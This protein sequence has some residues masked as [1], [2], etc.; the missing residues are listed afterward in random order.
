MQKILLS[1]LIFICSCILIF[2]VIALV[3]G[4]VTCV[5]EKIPFFI[6]SDSNFKKRNFFLKAFI[7][8]PLQFGK[9]LARF[10]PN[11]F[12][13]HGIIVFEGEQGAGKTIS[14]VQYAYTLKKMYPHCKII[15]N[16]ALSFEDK[17][18]SHWHD[19]TQFNNGLSGVVVNI[20]ECQNW[21][22]S[23]QSKD[24]PPEMLAVVTQNRKNR[25]IIL[26]TAQQ[27]YMLAKDIRT[28]ATEIRSAYTFL[29][30]LTFVIRRKP[31]FDSEGTP[32]KYKF[33]GMYFFVQSDELRSMYDTYAVI[34]NLNKSGFK[35][36][37]LRNARNR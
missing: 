21:F 37:E 30:C 1:I 17:S 6:R 34:E 29:G 11:T 27:F 23:K 20:D 33:L 7:D 35:P 2:S 12:Q 22:N 4:I 31:Y 16:T 3:S 26:M 19:L 32:I 8:F 25:R 36:E 13:P 24:F 10:N 9:D 18:L 5:K 28:Q 15:S 14:L